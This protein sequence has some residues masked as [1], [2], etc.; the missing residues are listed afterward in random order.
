MLIGLNTFMAEFDFSVPQ[1]RLDFNPIGPMLASGLALVT[2]RLADRP[3]GRAGDGRLFFI[4]R[5]G[6][7]GDVGPVLGQT[8]PHFPLY[9]AEAAAS[10]WSPSCWFA[11][12]PIDFRR[13]TFG[14]VAGVGDRNGRL[15][16]EWG[17]S[18]V[19]VVNPWTARM[20]PE[21]AILGLAMAVAAGTIGGFAGR[22][23]TLRGTPLPPAPYWALPLAADAALAVVL[24]TLPI[25]AGDGRRRVATTE[26]SPR[27]SRVAATFTL[28]PPDAAE[29]ARWFRSPRGRARRQLVADVEEVR[30][31]VYRSTEP[32]PVNGSW[33][34]ILRLHRDDEVLGVPSSCRATP[35]PGARGPGASRSSPASS[36]STRRTS[37][38]SRRASLGRGHDDLLPGCR[39]A[40][41]CALRRARLGAPA[42]PR[43]PRRRAGAAGGAREQPRSRPGHR[44]RPSRPG[45]TSRG[46]ATRSR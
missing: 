36:S 28:D 42:R 10:S 2:A 3:L 37:S 26:V 44:G 4:I 23:L 12:A 25:S 20:L 32:V 17:W 41:D 33:K 11:P 18:H 21:G 15:A 8:E 9:L 38:A 1:F 13:S 43:P 29:D 45:P 22:A 24:Y 39:R 5:G 31:G 34:S 30:P 16:A 6:C 19:W 40:H 35:D 46:P 7:H 14:A 27:R